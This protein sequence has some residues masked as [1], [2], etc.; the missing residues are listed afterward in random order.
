MTF[1]TSYLTTNLVVME[2]VVK[3]MVVMEVVVTSIT[4]SVLKNVLVPFLSDQRV[5][6]IF[7]NGLK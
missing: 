2:M 5:Y 7:P 3:E 1:L 4:T 6:Q